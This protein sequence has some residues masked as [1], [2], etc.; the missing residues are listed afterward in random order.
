MKTCVIAAILLVLSVPA[1]AS[2]RHSTPAQQKDIDRLYSASGRCL[3]YNPGNGSDPDYAIPENENQV[4]KNACDLS[5]RLQKKLGK[6]GFCL[7][8]LHHPVARCD[9]LRA[10]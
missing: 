1:L 4:S 8:S 10:H 9:A 5:A 2:P 7:T 3:E 6:R